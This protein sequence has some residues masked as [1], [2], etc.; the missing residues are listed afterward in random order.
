MNEVLKFGTDGWRG[1]IAEDYTFD[2]LRRCAAGYADWLLSEAKRTKTKRPVVVIG[3]DKRFQ[4]EDFA[5]SAAEVLA[6]HGVKVLLTDGATPTPVI[7][8]AVKAKKALGAINITASHNPPYD[9]G[10]KV[11]NYTGGA[12]DPEGLMRIEAAIPP[13][14]TGI[15]RMG[16]AEAGKKGMI[17]KFDASID[18]VENLKKLINLAPIKRAGL[19][20][21]QGPRTIDSP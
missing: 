19:K 9:N 2:N 1:R 16:Y 14:A 20:E 6:G 8:Y 15:A 4:S 13:S 18:Y 7:A 12:I 21:P 5:A 11:R 10:F 3:H 17:V